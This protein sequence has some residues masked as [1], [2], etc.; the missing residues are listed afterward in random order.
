MKPSV[1]A[2]ITLAVALAGCWEKSEQ[3]NVTDAIK[4]ALQGE[5]PQLPPGETQATLF[6]FRG[7]AAAIDCARGRKPPALLATR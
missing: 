2:L 3:Q 1:L 5:L 7:E 4:G 6:G